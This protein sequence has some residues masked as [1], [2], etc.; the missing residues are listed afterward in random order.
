MAGKNKHPWQAF[1][2]FIPIYVDETK[3]ALKALFLGQRDERLSLMCQNLS[4]SH[5]SSL[6]L[7][8]HEK[9]FYSVE[10][11]F[12]QHCSAETLLLVFAAV[13][14]YPP[15]FARRGGGWCTN[16]SHPIKRRQKHTT[17]REKETALVTPIHSFGDFFGR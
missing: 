12:L 2:A 17:T 9:K 1:A 5:S 15:P 11:A 10:G 13:S 14:A 3:T 4:R 16:R 7:R 8:V 6:L